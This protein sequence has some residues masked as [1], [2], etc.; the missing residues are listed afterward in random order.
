[1]DERLL[2]AIRKLNLN[3][4]R[5]WTEFHKREASL[6][7]TCSICNLSKK[8]KSIVKRMGE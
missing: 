8:R 1:M 4:S 3:E 7:L 2:L 5:G 6:R